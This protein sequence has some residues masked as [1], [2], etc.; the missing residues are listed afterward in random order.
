MQINE[1]CSLF[2]DLWMQLRD[3]KEHL[4]E[5]WPER[6]DLQLQEAFR[7]NELSAEEFSRRFNA[8]WHISELDPLFDVINEVHSACSIFNPSPQHA[9]EMDEQQFK[10]EI[11]QIARQY[12]ELT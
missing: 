7:R 5:T 6:Y 8:L 3:E 2:T 1:F 12:D 9:W 10:A 11:E 4:R